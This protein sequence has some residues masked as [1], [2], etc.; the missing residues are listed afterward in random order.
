MSTNVKEILQT[1]V[2]LYFMGKG[3]EE[4]SRTNDEYKEDFEDYDAVIQWNIGENIHMC[5]VIEAGQVTAH[6]DEVHN[7]PTVTFTVEDYSKA[8]EILTG[9][10]DGTSAYMSGDL[11]MVGDMQAGMKMGQVAEF[12]TDALSELLSS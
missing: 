6:L 2:L 3:L 12:L 5:L 1:K 9:A 10:T 11:K 8:K 4:I 7:E